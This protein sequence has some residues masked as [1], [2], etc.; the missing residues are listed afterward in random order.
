[1]IAVDETLTGSEQYVRLRRQYRVLR[2]VIAA[3]ADADSLEQTLEALV[4]A[5]ATGLE[6]DSAAL[7]LHEAPYLTIT[8]PSAQLSH[9][10]PR[11]LAHLPVT[12]D[13]PLLHGAHRVG[14]LRFGRLSAAVDFDE[15]D[16]TFA[17]DILTQAASVIERV[18]REAEAQRR[19]ARAEALREIG[20]TVSAE[21]D[22]GCLLAVT[23]DQVA[24]LIPHESCWL[25]LWDE[26]TKELDCRFHMVAGKRVPSLE[27][28]L[29]QGHGLAWAL[30]EGRRTLNVADSIE[31]CLRRGLRPVECDDEPQ[32]ATSP[33]LGV[34][35]LTGGRLVGVMAVQRSLHPF[36]DDEAATLELLGG[37]I[38]AALENARRYADAREL[39]TCDPLT[40]LVN[41]RALHERLD[42]ELLHAARQE[43]A[44]TV[45]MADL[46]N[47]KL[48]ND[49][50]GHPLGDQVL[51]LV[52]E[53]LRA[54]ARGTDIV[55]RYGGDEFLVVL[56][57]SDEEAAKSYI[58]RVCAHVAS[59]FPKLG[60]HDAI[61]IALSAGI[62]AYPCDAR[63]ARELIDHADRALYASKRRAPRRAVVAS[64]FPATIAQTQVNFDV[65]DGLLAAI[66]A[67]DG[68]T[69]AHSA[70]V[71]ETAL[72]LAAALA[73]PP[74]E[75]ETLR[76]AARLHDVGKISLPD[77]ILHK[78]TPLDTIEQLLVR[79]H[80]EFGALI[81]RG[82]SGPQEVVNP[83]LSHHEHW[84]GQGYP[85]NLR[86]EA[87]PLL[88]RILAIADA[89]SAMTLDRPY[90][91]KL[92][93]AARLA[94]L[95]TGAGKQFDP[96]LV[97][98]LCAAREE[99]PRHFQRYAS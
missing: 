91:A 82:I 81:L 15:Q 10:E 52:A 69:V 43:H 46:D 13:L 1:M 5:L 50:Y 27:R 74:H 28:R 94:Q 40:G 7:Q 86:G 78:T 44:L 61:P 35:L 92:S 73:L 16:H 53:A 65:I 80:V 62:A 71:V 29:R 47:F 42:T 97:A 18:R 45:I 34:P 12:L 55:G 68:Y 48:F 95:R 17:E 24:R 33:W 8:W 14:M 25:A 79:Q 30:L 26:A 3:M 98:L 83:I 57:G 60:A 89:Y 66:D 90:R 20:R 77:H 22:F 88:G 31:E 32:V 49:T 84:D 72:F 67:K 70:L 54:E 87:I 9:P 93:P 63:A 51:R 37:Q 99:P 23:R 59:L 41:H 6:A 56:P 38:A 19:I 96:A 75:R 21:L 64:R 39:A 4:A 76:L 11:S 36:D 58:A 85:Y 2:H